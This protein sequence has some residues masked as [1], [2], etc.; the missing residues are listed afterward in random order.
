MDNNKGFQQNLSQIDDQIG[1]ENI[2][3]DFSTK[4]E[5]KDNQL[6]V[7]AVKEALNCD[8]NHPNQS[9]SKDREI[10]N[11]LSVNKD[12]IYST[13]AR[14]RNDS[15]SL[16]NNNNKINKLINNSINDKNNPRE[17]SFS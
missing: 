16:S 4:L 6:L 17:Y 8:L 15:N 11:N 12:Y 2:N 3:F 1:K 7:N 14:K 5:F 10:D 13:N 9:Q